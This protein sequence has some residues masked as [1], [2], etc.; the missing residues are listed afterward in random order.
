[1]VRGV[2]GVSAVKN[3]VEDGGKEVAQVQHLHMEELIVQKDMDLEIKKIA[4]KKNAPSMVRGVSGPNVLN[5]VAED[6]GKEVV[7]IQHHQMEELIV[8]KDMDLEIKRI[9]TK[10]V[11]LSMVGGVSGHLVLNH[12]VEVGRR[13]V[14]QIRSLQMEELIVLKNMDK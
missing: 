1:M 12:V 6:G 10:K 13:E 5:H 4:T 7:Q 9:A 11:A 2:S 8:Q 3:V 14:V